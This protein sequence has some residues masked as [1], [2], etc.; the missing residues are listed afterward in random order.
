MLRIE[1]LK[2]ENNS[3]YQN[4]KEFKRKHLYVSMSNISMA[5]L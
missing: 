5:C 3:T 4:R 1:V 2:D